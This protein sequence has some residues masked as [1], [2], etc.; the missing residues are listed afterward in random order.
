MDMSRQ[1]D[2]AVILA[3]GL[4][5][6]QWTHRLG[7]AGMAAM[8]ALP[9]LRATVDQHIAH[10]RDAVTDRR[11]R[12]HPVMLAAYADGVADTVTAKGWSV[13]EH[14]TTGWERASWPSVHL[15]AVCVLAETCAL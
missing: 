12:V 7:A 15:L 11:G 13:R 3:A 10:I 8:R 4:A 14:T 2:H 5:L 1:S 6:E 9:G